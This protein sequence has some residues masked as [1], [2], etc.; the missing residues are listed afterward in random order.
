MNKEANRLIAK[1]LV[2][3]QVASDGGKKNDEIAD[4]L[5]DESREAFSKAYK[6]KEKYVL[7]AIERINRNRTMD[8]RYSVMADDTFQGMP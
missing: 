5:G 8:F 1:Y 3:A 2:L 4:I 7:K 6:I